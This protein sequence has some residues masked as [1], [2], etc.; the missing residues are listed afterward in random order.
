MLA[1]QPKMLRPDTKGRITLGKLAEGVSR[2]RLIPGK[3]NRIILEPLV[4]IPASEKWLFDNKT[5]LKQVKQG[6]K[7]SAN[8]HISS[9]GSF[10]Q[11]LNEEID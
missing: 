11:Y 2:F 5:A 7:D 1:H 3:Q 6:L 10:A 9:R 4:E 8:G